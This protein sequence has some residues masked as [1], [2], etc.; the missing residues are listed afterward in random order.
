[1]RTVK[2]KKGRYILSPEEV[3]KLCDEN[4]IGIIGILGSTLTGEYED[5]E[6]LDRLVDEH[7]RKQGIIFLSMW[8]QQVVVL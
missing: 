1:M 8:M 2:L 3:I 7:N 5:I 4:T 6:K